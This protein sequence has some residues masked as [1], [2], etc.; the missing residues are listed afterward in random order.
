MG[1]FGTGKKGGH[2]KYKKWQEK[3]LYMQN[4]LHVLVGK[5]DNKSK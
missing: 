5:R 1:R 3:E 4:E 2:A